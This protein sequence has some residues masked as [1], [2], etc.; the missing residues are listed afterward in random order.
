MPK[1]DHEVVSLAVLADDSPAWRPSS[2]GYSRWGFRL[3]MDL[4]TV[5]LLDLAE[6][7]KALEVS[8]NPFALVTMAQLKARATV[9]TCRSACAGRCA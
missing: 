5:K 7:W 4:P 6:D 8:R 1:Y 2:F 9:A 3:Q